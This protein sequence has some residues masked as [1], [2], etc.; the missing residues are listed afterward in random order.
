MRTWR[1]VIVKTCPHLY[2]DIH[3]GK[4]MG[5]S[6]M[7]FGFEVGDGWGV[8]L[9]ELSDKLEELILKEPEYRRNFYRAIQVKEKYGSLR[10]Y[11]YSSTDEMEE[12]IREAEKKSE[13]T[14]EVCGVPAKI[15]KIGWMYKCIC[16]SC[17][18]KK[19]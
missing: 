6:L 3:E 1:E 7:C 12:L 17:E 10:F 15:K 5:E 14:C 8:I 19:D 9:E 4:T 18:E 16:D 2:A 13:V 11:M